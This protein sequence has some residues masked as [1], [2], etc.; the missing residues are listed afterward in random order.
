M[1]TLSIL[2][3]YNYDNTIFDGFAAPEGMDKDNLIANLLLEL[4]ELEVLY[5]SA[6]MMKQA[7]FIWSTKMLEKWTKLLATTKYEYDPISNYDR[8]ETWEDIGNRISQSSGTTSGNS[9]SSGKSKTK[10]S[11]YNGDTMVPADETEDNAEANTNASSSAESE[12]DTVNTRS[13]RAYG[14]IG[15]TTTQQMIEEER[16]V[17]QFV[18]ADTIIRD[19]AD[20]FCI[21]VW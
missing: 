7:I 14:N 15:V 19:F 11:G 6:P 9:N 3:L 2:G 20:R 1:A 18:V 12:E 10:V 13:G 5:P 8:T 4:A 21:G 16:R 17:V